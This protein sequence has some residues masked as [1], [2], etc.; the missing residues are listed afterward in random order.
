MNRTERELLVEA[1]LTPQRGYH[2]D[3]ALRFH[4]AFFDLDSAGREEL[5]ASLARQRA[6]EAAASPDGLS[7]TARAVLRRVR[8]G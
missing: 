8:G 2:P 6:I 1:A 3:G 5:F 7:A 4:P